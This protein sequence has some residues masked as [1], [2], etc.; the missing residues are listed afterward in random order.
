M[1]KFL[2]LVI[3]LPVIAN[4]TGVRNFNS[5]IASSVVKKNSSKIIIHLSKKG[6]LVDK[7]FYGSHF[8]SYSEM[9]NKEIMN[10]LKIG[11]IRV[12]GNEF[13]LNNWKI[14]KTL[15]PSGEIKKTIDYSLLSKKLKNLDIGGIFQINLTGFQ[16]E[17]IGSNY[18]ISRSFTDKS[19]YEM[20]KY[21]NGTEKLNISDFC[22]GNEFSIWH[23]T[24]QKVWPTQDGIS[25]DEYIERYLKYAIAIRSAQD[26]INGDPNS[27][28]IWGPEISTSWY[29]WNTGN[30]E[31]DCRWTEVAGQVSCSYGNGKFNNFIPYF[32]HRIKTAE[33]DQL[34]NPKGY[35]LIDYLSIHYYPNFRKK[36]N[37]PG[38]IVTDS[39]GNQ[40]ISQMLESTRVL[41]DS[42]FIN[43]IDK[44]SF[45]NY[46]PNILGRMQD[47][48]KEYYPELKLA[49]NEFAIDSDYRT[50][51]YHPIVR[52]LYLADSIGILTNSNVSFLN[53]FSLSSKSGANSPWSLIEGGE[54]KNLFYMYK[55]FTN[56]F[57]GNVLK[58]EDTFGDKVNAYATS[59]KDLIN[60]AIVNKE[61]LE[62]KVDIFLDNDLDNK[63]ATFSAPP[64]SASILKI[65]NGV[66]NKKRKIKLVQYGA[67]EMQIRLKLN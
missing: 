49:V 64:W 3:F 33:K 39:S 17:L 44:S 14:S 11:K 7:N 58:V 21:L 65:E 25:A 29:D 30:F 28:K 1:K 22:L 40:L 46:S 9:P 54:R 51:N 16:P 57:V 56:N 4:C 10:E 13:D 35:K 12:G 47:W 18:V 24:H 19:A 66:N 41:H 48:I 42:T 37:D 27:I 53:L 59:T 20:V 23:E 50:N 60:L 36:I 26:D 52:P 61:A 63:I 32:L 8:D 67:K 6:M 45:R 5:E 34:L 15:S 31:V 55:L 62:K 2:I 38:S 43:S